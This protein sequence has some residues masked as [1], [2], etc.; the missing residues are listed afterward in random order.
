MNTSGVLAGWQPL[1]PVQEGMWFTQRLESLA[2][3]AQSL[4]SDLMQ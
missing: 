2:D 4:L 1:S 3:A